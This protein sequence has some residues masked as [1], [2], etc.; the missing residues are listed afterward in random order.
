MHSANR[1]TSTE[2]WPR[3]KKPLYRCCDWALINKIVSC[4]KLRHHCF[5]VF[6]A[7]LVYGHPICLLQLLDILFVFGKV[8]APIDCH[9]LP[10]CSNWSTILINFW[11]CAINTATS[12]SSFLVFSTIKPFPCQTSQDGLQLRQYNHHYPDWNNTNVAM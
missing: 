1:V 7:G 5:L 12:S 9:S 3:Q 10:G 4:S 6:H 2:L 8:I 11:G